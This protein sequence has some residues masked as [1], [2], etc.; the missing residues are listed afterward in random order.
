MAA[1]DILTWSTTNDRSKRI[2]SQSNTFDFQSIRIG[3]DTLTISEATSTAF[4]FNGNEIQSIA[5]P[6]AATSAATKGYVDAVATGLTVKASVQ[7]ATTVALAANTYANGT[8]GVGATLTGNAN[9]AIGTIDGYTPS[10]NDRLL[11]K[12]ESAALGNGIY[13]LTQV[14]DGSNPYILTR[15]TD[16]DTCQPA[17]NP[18]VTSGMFMFIE[19]GSTQSGQGWVM[20]TPDPITLGTTA[21]A[22]TQFSQATSFTAGN[23]IQISSGVISARIDGTSLQFSSGVITLTIANSTLSTNGSGLTVANNGITATQLN[24]SVAGNGLTGGGGTSLS[25]VVN[26]DATLAVDAN[27]VRLNAYDSYTNDNAGSITVGQIV[28]IKTNGHVDLASNAATNNL[29]QLGIVRDTSIATTASGNIY[30][31]EGIK[32]GGFSSLTPGAPVYVSGTAG[33]VTQTTSGFT[34]GQFLY[35]VGYALTATTIRFEP[36]FLIEW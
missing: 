25:V 36:E 10:V 11:I 33:A 20:T 27:G 24:T 29:F 7:A 3:T 34:A 35:Q 6:T 14:G 26:T 32:L 17:S 13:T 5:S 15:S 21:L 22:F 31:Q 12:N 4:N 8:A 23:G 30:T 1:F 28:Y 18:E 2:P 9:G 19:Q 16:A